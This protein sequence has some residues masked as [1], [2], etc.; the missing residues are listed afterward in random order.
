MDDEIS[1]AMSGIIKGID[2][3]QPGDVFKVINI[4]RYQRQIVGESG[5]RYHR[6]GETYFFILAQYDGVLD[7]F[8]VQLQFNQRDDD[9]MQTGAP[10]IG[11]TGPARKPK[12]FDT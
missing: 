6:V 5:G 3:F 4:P 9:F 11:Q 7:H 2:E 8:P 12:D 10:V 1:V